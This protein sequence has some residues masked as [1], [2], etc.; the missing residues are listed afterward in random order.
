MKRL[1]I[2]TI[3]GITAGIVAVQARPVANI[4]HDIYPS[5]PAKRQA[6]DLCILGDPNFNRLDLSAREACYRHAASA[7]TLE[8]APTTTVSAPNPVDLKQDAGRGAA[9]RN[10]IRV[11]QATQG[12]LR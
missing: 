12:S 3:I 9:P 5:D 11:V 4:L 2:A 1:L 6:L 8:I 7:P 10:D